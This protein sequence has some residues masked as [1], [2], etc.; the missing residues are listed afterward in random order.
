MRNHHV[1]HV[2]MIDIIA[3]QT[4]KHYHG[5]RYSGTTYSWHPVWELCM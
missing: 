4:R 1:L 2:F 3:I 5:A